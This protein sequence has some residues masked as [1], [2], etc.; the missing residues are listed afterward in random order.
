MTSSKKLLIVSTVALSCR[1]LLS[2]FFG[3]PW[4]MYVWIKS[5]EIALRNINIY[6]LENP[7][8]YPW[9]FYAYPPA[10]LYW[11]I[12]SALVN[13]FSENI[14]LTIFITKL[15]IILSDISVGILLY[16]IALKL[17]FH[18]RTALLVCMLW[19]FNPTVFFI[20]SIW[21]M[22]DS[23]A[24]LFMLLGLL[25]IIDGRYGR[26]GFYIGA[27]A[28]IKI[29]PALLIPP[30]IIFLIKDKKCNIREIIKNL[31]LIPAVVF[32]VIS[33]PFLGTPIQ[34]LKHILQHTESIGSFTYWVAL[35]TIINISI[36]WPIPMII[37]SVALLILYHKFKGGFTEYVKITAGSILLFLATSP[38]VNIQHTLIF[39]PLILLLKNFWEDRRFSSYFVSFI[40]VSI[41]WIISSIF[42]L[43]GY[44]IDWI[45]RIYAPETHEYGLWEVLLVVSAVAGGV[46]IFRLSFE[47]L[48]LGKTVDKL[49][50][51]MWG[52]LAIIIS[53]IMIF[54]LQPTPVGIGLPKLEIRI[55]IPESVDSAFIPRSTVSIESF[56]KHYDVNY[57][58]LAWSPDFI[59]CYDMIDEDR[60]ISQYA[61]FR[62]GSNKWAIKDVKWLI[63][64]LHSRNIN[65]LLGVYLNVEDIKPHYGIQGYSV[66]WIKKHPEVIGF[67]KVLLFN[68]TLRIN[69]T[70][71][72]NYSE[73]FSK[74]L[75]KIVYE[76]N[77]DGVYLMNWGSWRIRNIDYIIPLLQ[78][79]RKEI[80]K[81]I[82]IESLPV[83]NDVEH[84]LTLLSLAD[85]VVL[86]TAPW[87]YTVYYVRTDNVTLT[88]Y[89]NY[90]TTLLDSLD[91]ND[92]KRLLFSLHV[93]DFVDGWITPASQL[94]VEAEEL[95][96]SGLRT[97]YAIYYTSRYVPYKISFIQSF[98]Q[99]D[100][101]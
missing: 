40:L 18:E 62:M 10:W 28:S 78:D 94:N 96:S 26:A 11:L 72:I 52:V 90:I 63:E 9:G 42:V 84:V 92:K 35:S 83:T 99:E 41:C 19:L 56:L 89:K 86:K 8:D 37:Y 49:I 16:R 87:V 81:E 98:I 77:F 69:N 12:I 23:M 75:A 68:N 22:F 27:G 34:Y 5:G 91:K 25:N 33:L 67:D 93:L 80:D 58:V 39:I 47:A 65:V 64:E 44:S 32:S 73:Y 55:A 48:G 24:T 38:K 1:L 3:H 17:G 14:Y 6:T 46:L 57:V 70:Y 4:D 51:K 30:T 88:D 59:N 2:S 31:V 82:F 97:G 85:Y 15:P 13:M 100:V 95:Y 7:A 60:D 79:L 43:K 45:G 20:S 29:L 74:K 21:G 66:D 36:F 50:N 54:T 61:R 53:F 71:Y 101:E 76:M